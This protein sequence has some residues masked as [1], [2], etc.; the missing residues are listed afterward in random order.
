MMEKTAKTNIYYDG[1]CILCSSE[2]EFYRKRDSHGKLEFTDI[3]LPSFDPGAEGLDSKE[4]QKVFHVRNKHGSITK[5][6]DG[7]IEIWNELDSLKFLVR[8]AKTPFIRSL[9]EVSY[10]VFIKVRPFLPRKR[11][12]EANCHI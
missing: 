10:R 4:V 11:C 2:I 6:V 9:L 5:G 7:F 8:F 1:G 12:K 3:S